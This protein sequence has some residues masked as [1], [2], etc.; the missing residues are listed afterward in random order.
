L[1]PC[2]A[3]Q[4]TSTDVSTT[5]FAHSKQKR[6]TPFAHSKQ[7]RR[8]KNPHQPTSLPADAPEKL[9]YAITRYQT[10]TTRLYQ[11]LASRL[12]SQRA[13][14]SLPSSSPAFLVGNKYTLADICVFSWVNWGEWA[15]VQPSAFPEIK[16]WME[17]I[18]K[19][20]A[21]IRGM[22]VPDDFKKMKETMKDEKKAEEYAKQ[23]SGWIMKGMK[24][25]E[26]RKL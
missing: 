20:P 25:E 23:S 12:A 22:N 21:V 4:I 26:G 15:G 9:P 14:H 10:E 19:R 3:K 24:E 6:R 16:P 8:E 5:P 17:A 18:E 7:K 13:S 1:A 11:V 2:K